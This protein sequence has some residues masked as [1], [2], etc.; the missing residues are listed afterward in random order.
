VQLG[1]HPVAVGGRLYTNRGKTTIFMRKNNKYIRRNNNV[2]VHN[3][4]HRKK[5]YMYHIL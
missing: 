4:D 5:H 1:F 2:E 3:I